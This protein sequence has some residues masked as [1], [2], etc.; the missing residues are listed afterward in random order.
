MTHHHIAD[1]AL[2]WDFPEM[3]IPGIRESLRLGY[4]S[5]RGRQRD[6]IGIPADSSS[7]DPGLIPSHCRSLF[8]TGSQNPENPKLSRLSPEQRWLW[9]AIFLGWKIPGFLEFSK[10]R[11][12][13]RNPKSQKS[14]TALFLPLKS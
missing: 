8:S 13:E 6:G 3:K 1:M 10:L 11:F 9:N 12:F 5:T 4:F 14:Q 7:Q 2:G